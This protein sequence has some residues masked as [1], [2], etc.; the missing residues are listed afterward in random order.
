[1]T[2][3]I[4][5]RRDFFR[6]SAAF[7]ALAVVG[8][9]ALA[10][11]SKVNTGPVTLDSLKSAGKI[12]IGIAGEQPYGFTDA[13]GKVTGEAPEV[14]RAVFKNLG[15][16]NIEAQQVS[17]D[18]LIPS[19]NAHQYDMVAAGMNIK[20]DRCGQAAFSVADY[21]AKTSF[22]VK[23]GNPKGIKTFDDVIA[24]KAKI[25]VLNGAVELGYATDSGVPDGMITKVE[26]QDDLLRQVKDGRVDCGALTDISLHDVV[27]KNPD[28]G[29]EVTEG[30]DPVI[31]GKK[32]L[33]AGGFVFRKDDTD[34]LKAFNTELKK[35]QGNGEWV[36]IA[37]PFGFSQANVPTAEVTTE[38][39]CQSG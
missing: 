7:G 12:K 30:F 36:K 26:T 35:L 27:K 25:A 31:K 6:R 17:F 11:C 5:T 21:S 15:V 14:A 20:P 22:L 18:S 2:G 23:K 10:A 37:S 32:V 19:L 24:K 38:K 28:A 8:P 4:W 13:S 39:L 16:A 33:S 34:L 9:A 29:L 1:M 3:E